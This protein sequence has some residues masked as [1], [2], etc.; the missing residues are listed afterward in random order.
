M[1]PTGKFS[2]FESYSD[3]ARPHAPR[4]GFQTDAAGQIASELGLASARDVTFFDLNARSRNQ[5][6]HAAVALVP[7]A[8]LA[9]AGLTAADPSRPVF[10][11]AFR[12]S[13]NA[14]AFVA[15]VN[16]ES[17]PH[18]VRGGSVEVHAGFWDSLHGRPAPAT[19]DARGS[20]PVPASC[21]EAVAAHIDQLAA[22]HGAKGH[23]QVMVTGLSLVRSGDVCACC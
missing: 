5:F 11:A 22:A 15:D 8:S 10:V 4:A 14:A 6:C 20:G 1:Y 23:L 13:S 2:A 16:F 9:R 3:C 19:C 21:A 18:T 7:A 17:A 12:G